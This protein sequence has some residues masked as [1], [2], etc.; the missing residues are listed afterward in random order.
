MGFIGGESRDQSSMFP[1][2]RDD[3]VG[4]DHPIRVIDRYVEVQDLRALG[5]AR[6]EAAATGRP[7]YDPRLMLKLYVY[8]YLHRVSSSRRLE[9]EASR[10]VEL[11]WLLGKLVP[12][13]KSIAD[14]RRDNG[15]ALRSLCRSF[16]LFCVSQGLM[17]GELIAIDGSK[18]AGVNHRG[19]NFSAERLAQRLAVLDAKIAAH[20][21]AMD[22]HDA[23]EASTAPDAEAVRQALSQ[24]Q[25]R[26]TELEGHQQA[27]KQ[28]GAT[29]V[30]LTDPDARAMRG[31]T[32]GGGLVGYNVQTAVDAAHKLIVTFE[33]TQDGNDR[34]QLSR[35]ARAAQE[36]LGVKTL[37][38]VADAGYANGAELPAC[39]A[40]GI[41]AYVPAQPANNT[42]RREFKKADFV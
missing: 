10:N 15:V 30:S 2:R 16:S 35:Q 39:E 5:F 1:A 6:F 23:D 37:T 42:T 18:F 22:R 36:I 4:A 7:G 40:A 12:D 19:R 31:G 34:N 11:M 26:K 14:F 38:V 20:L 32:G 3:Y 25:A 29:Q 33:V 13:F 41:T 17:K 27:L 28:T 9:S 8:G 24:L 21:E